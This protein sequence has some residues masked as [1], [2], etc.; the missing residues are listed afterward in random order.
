MTSIKISNST[1]PVLGTELIRYAKPVLT[2]IDE[3][4]KV[5]QLKVLVTHFILQNGNEVSAQDLKSDFTRD[6]IADNNFFVE[7]KIEG[8]QQV[9]YHHT[10]EAV[11]VDGDINGELKPEFQTGVNLFGAYDYFDILQGLPIAINTIKAAEIL[12][13]D[14]RGKF[15]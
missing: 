1:L 12:Y 11:Y 15:N 6:L 7:I 10:K 4:Q 2:I 9:P 3:L 13:N 5:V 14:S 8:G